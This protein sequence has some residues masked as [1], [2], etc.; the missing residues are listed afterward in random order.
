VSVFFSFFFD[1]TNVVDAL[2]RCSKQLGTNAWFTCEFY[3]YRIEQAKLLQWS[4]NCW[5]KVADAIKEKEE[6]MKKPPAKKQMNK[7]RN[8]TK[9]VDRCKKIMFHLNGE[10]RYKLEQWFGTNRWTYSQ[11][12]QGI[13]YKKIKP[14][15]TSTGA[16]CVNGSA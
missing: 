1:V 14:I 6:I 2:S 12:L 5:K 13:K 3:D 10:D 4:Y 8:E 9:L 7:R 11:I 16:Y 15:K